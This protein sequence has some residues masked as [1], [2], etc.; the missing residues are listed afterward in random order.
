MTRIVELGTI[1]SRGQ[2]AIPSKIRGEL[3]LNEGEKV[4]FV[5]DG[6]TLLIKKV[7]TDKTWEELT[8]PL[9]EAAKKSGF[10][11]SE[12][13]DLVHKFRRERRAKKQ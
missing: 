9:R 7:M 12:V 11:E 10:K 2:I 4:L 3:E 6:D 5:L 1:S 13:V 8:K